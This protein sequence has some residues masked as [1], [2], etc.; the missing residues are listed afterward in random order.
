MPEF[1]FSMRDE[2]VGFEVVLEYAR[3][4]TF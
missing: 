4:G 2:G 1:F 3:S